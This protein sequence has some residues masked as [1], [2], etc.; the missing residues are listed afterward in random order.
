MDEEILLPK[1]NLNSSNVSIEIVEKKE[2]S[3]PKV[4]IELKKPSSYRVENE[5]NPYSVPKVVEE[6]NI[7]VEDAD[8]GI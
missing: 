6:E 7:Q 2:S 5:F 3:E 8:L 4:E 1:R